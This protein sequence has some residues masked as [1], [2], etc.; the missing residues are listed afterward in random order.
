MEREQVV[1]EGVIERIVYKNYDTG[2]TVLQMELDGEPLSVVGEALD[3]SEGE[4][5]RATGSF[6]SHPVHGRQFRATYFEHV[7]PAGSAAI[8]RYLAGGA[9]RGIGPVLAKRIVDRFGD[10]TLFILENDPDSLVQIRGIS[11]QKAQEIGES[12]RSIVGVR[13]VMVLLASHGIA[14]AIAVAAWKKWGAFAA[15]TI[16]TDPY[17]LCDSEIGLPFE[18]ADAL[19]FALGVEQNAP[20][21]VDGG[22]LFVMTHNLN[23]GHVCLPLGKLTATAAGLLGVPVA[24]AEEAVARLR[25]NGQAVLDTV[26]GE[27]YLYLP[28]QFAAEVGIADRIGLM[29]AFAVPDQPTCEEEIDAVERENSITY[30]ARQREAIRTAVSS[31]VMILTGGP[32]TGKTTILN[33]ILTLLER[34]GMTVALAAPTGRAAK[35]MSEVS[36]REAK[37]IH[38]LLE[39]E[40]GSARAGEVTFKRNERNPLQADAVII[41]EMSMVDARLFAAL[42]RGMRTNSRLVLVGDPDQIPSVGAGNVLLDLIESERVPVIHL[43]EIFRQA[44]QSLIVTSAHAI[45]SGEMP[46]LSRTD[47]DVFFL[48][49]PTAADAAATVA[50]LCARRLPKAYGLDP[51][52]DIQVIAPSRQGGAGTFELNR[53]LQE[54]LNPPAPHKSETTFNGIL[55]REGDKVM[56]VRNNYEIEWSR[57]DGEEGLGVFNGDIGVITMIDNA[58]RTVGI[59]FDERRTYLPFDSLSEIELAYAVTVHKSQGNEFEAVILPLVGRHRRLSYRNLIY[60]AVTRARRLLIFVGESRAIAAMVE[61]NRKTLRYTCLSARLRETPEFS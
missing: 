11:P 8:L 59:S 9:I 61:N 31:P 48:S 24:D 16:E 3:L 30:A 32:G 1:L 46:E 21:R 41:D 18:Q 57:P 38:R 54:A 52:R 35:R 23:N 29:M 19:A 39:V 6:T 49:R 37:T 55:F 53:R 15:H 34:R 25:E 27:Q 4:E 56:Q 58:T 13:A 60:T 40:P 26:E 10:D 22:V 33:G 12:Y 5:I 42:L 2:F 47:G 36:N 44:A 14:P 20:C 50:D 28:E 7:L 43:T 51:A 17:S 45:V